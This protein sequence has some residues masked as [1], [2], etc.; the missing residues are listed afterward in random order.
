MAPQSSLLDRPHTV[1]PAIPPAPTPTGPAPIVTRLVK[2]Q[3]ICLVTRQLATLL[4]AGMPL[5]PALGALQ[6]QFTG[7]SQRQAS[8]AQVL[9]RIHTRVVGGVSLSDAL[10]EFPSLFSATYCSMVA[11]GEMGGTLEKV[12]SH[13]ADSLEKRQTLT[14]KIR[15]ALAYPFLMGIVAIGVVVFLLSHVVPSITQIFL[16]MNRTLPMPTRILIAISGFFER[17]YLL[18]LLALVVSGVGLLIYQK[19][20]QGRKRWDQ[21]VLRLPLLR[22]LL[23]QIEITRLSRTLG[24]LLAGGVPVL[25]ALEITRDILQNTGLQNA[26]SEVREQVQKGKGLADAM[27]R[28]GVFPP[29]VCHVIATSQNTGTMESGLFN[30]ADMYETQLEATLKTL[31]SL[32]EPLILLVMGVLVGFI[33]MAVLLPI[34]DINQAI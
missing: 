31:T 12:L 29:M 3:D 2:K 32:L 18:V 8:L 17:Y 4:R 6:E 30:I 13:M 19:S 21:L 23:L 14:L 25:R 24:M 22:S 26:W 16:E 5:A 1:T 15:A 33:V 27:K 34:F 11:S 9:G 28:T 10:T 7:V 20:P